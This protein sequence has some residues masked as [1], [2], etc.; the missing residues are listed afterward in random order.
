[1]KLKSKNILLCLSILSVGC[2]SMNSLNEVKAYTTHQ[3]CKRSDQGIAQMEF[4]KNI[5]PLE[6]FKTG[7]VYGGT[8]SYTASNNT[9]KL[10]NTPDQYFLQM[11]IF[12]LIQMDMVLLNNMKR[13]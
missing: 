7:S 4:S 12:L 2:L 6:K 10:T 9:Y 11:I 8:S 3:L 1:M 13:I 5:F